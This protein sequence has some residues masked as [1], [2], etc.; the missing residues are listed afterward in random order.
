M[1]RIIYGL[2]K[3]NGGDIHV[4]GGCEAP[5]SGSAAETLT[6]FISVVK[7]TNPNQLNLKERLANILFR[8]NEMS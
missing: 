2:N 7:N 5:E 6:R 1:N 4:R 8:A 3:D